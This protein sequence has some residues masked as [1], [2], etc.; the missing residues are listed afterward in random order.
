MAR[1]PQPGSDQG[2]WGIIL[3]DFLSVTH[4][5][6]G[7][8]KADIVQKSMLAPELQTSIENA[9]ALAGGIAP[10]ATTTSKGILRLS[11]DLTGNALSPLIRTGAVTGGTG[12]GIATNT[13]TDT[14]IHPTANIAKS[15]LAPLSLV[16]SDISS[17]AAIVQSK[18]ANL[19][20]DLAGK[21][22]VVHTHAISDVSGLQ[23]VIDA[24]ANSASLSTV[25]TTG[26]YT[27]LT[28]K[29]TIPTVS[30]TSVNALT[31]AVTLTAADVGA[32]TSSHNHT[33]SDVTSLQAALDDKAATVHTHSSSAITDFSASTSAVIGAKLIAGENVLI[34][35]DLGSGETT[36]SATAAPG[37]GTGSDTVTSVAGRIGDVVIV[38]GDI[39]SGTFN[40]ARI[41]DLD[42]AKITTGTFDIAR[43]PTGS[44]STTVSIGNHGHSAATGSTDG[45]LSAADKTKLDGVA[46]SANNYTHPSGDGNL[47]IPATGTTNNN[48][49]LK[50]GATAGS[51]AWG[52]LAAADVGAASAVHAHAGSDITSGVIGINYLPTGTSDTTVAFGDHT[53]SDY[54]LVDHIHD[55]RYYTQTEIDTSLSLKLDSTQKG[56]ANGLA[57]LGSD[58][59][60]P[61]SQLPAIA[62]NETFTA[63]SQLAMLALDA[64]RGDMCIRTDTSQTY[65]LASDSP[66]TLADWKE[67]IASG[68]VTSV[69][70]RTGAITLAKAD[71]GLDAVDNT[72]DSAKPVSTAQQTALD[73]KANAADVYSKTAADGRYIRTVNGTAPDGT[74]NVVVTGE[75]GPQGPQGETGEPGPVGPYAAYTLP[76]YIL[77]SN[78]TIANVPSDFPEGGLVFKKTA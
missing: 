41:P 3:N 50:A 69:S 5:N 36:I 49:V 39:N 60:I 57:T 42:S 68:Q 1:L 21:A 56:A 48:K 10:D 73:L 11:G 37:G 2:T 23:T 9:E 27:D 8:L 45:F 52:T 26:S 33:V 18:I 16:D 77:E 72:A 28:N 19:V 65:V 74:G 75:A 25:A 78:Q 67:I 64:Q 76:T 61:S 14:N 7:S 62:I 40:T 24:K 4:Q 6:D 58:S 13:I 31:G 30:V 53:H 35:Y 15:K 70:G 44:S 20:S 12:G 34:N 54:S 17:S 51:I 29:P 71:V 46:T 66:S 43:I 38:A 22:S 63:N 55:D 32:A 59:K 47:H